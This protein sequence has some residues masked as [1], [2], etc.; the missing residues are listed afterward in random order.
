MQPDDE[1]TLTLSKWPFYVADGVLVAIALLIATVG[2]G[3]LSDFQVACCVIAVALGAALFVL[4]YAVEYTML[5]SEMADDRSAELHL[6]QAQLKRFE[7]VLSAYGER[8][9]GLEPAAG[10]AP[11]D[12]LLAAAVDQKFADAAQ[13]VD[14]LAAAVAA[15]QEGA[16]AQL[17]ALNALQAQVAGLRAD[18]GNAAAGDADWDA[19]QARI[20]A[21]ESRLIE[22]LKPIECL[23]QRLQALE[24]A[25]KESPEK[26][27][28][29]AARQR[30]AS[31][32]GLLHR[33][34][35]EKQDTSSTA[36]SRIIDAKQKV[37]QPSAAFESID[38]RE[39][40]DASPEVAEQPSP[41]GGEVDPG[42][43]AEL[44]AEQE[45]LPAAKAASADDDSP[46]APLLERDDEASAVQ[47]LAEAAAVPV[48]EAPEV[49]AQSGDVEAVA[50]APLDELFGEVFQPRVSRASVKKNDTVCT[51]SILIGIGNKPY[52][53]GS[54][55][56][57]NWDAGVP[58]EFE[59]IGKWRWVAPADFD[60]S[61]EL[62]VFR[63][64]EEADRKGVYALSAGQKLEVTPV[65]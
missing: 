58:M 17:A 33:A 28:P 51:V 38:P 37:A 48:G 15:T 60:G 40:A 35:Q 6:V 36:V 3:Q 32:A 9:E 14:R 27:A 4:P 25:A 12:Q 50:E 34:M 55:A 7:A 62:Q 44:A 64:D 61:V 22:A 49:A 63:N 20:G 53:R 24:I 8:L 42:A 59:A 30:R 52:L 29:R 1:A 21:L 16:S 47:S 5:R 46:A 43:G 54:G 19:V 13:A 18:A 57:L 56:G 23:D 65:F 11:Q 41:E 45:V 31:D 26:R 2:G 10:S 39:G